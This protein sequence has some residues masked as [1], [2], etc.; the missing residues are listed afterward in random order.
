MKQNG[1]CKSL[2][3][4]ELN[5]RLRLSLLLPEFQY[6]LSDIDIPLSICTSLYSTCCSDLNRNQEPKY[7]GQSLGDPMIILI[8]AL[9]L[10]KISQDFVRRKI[11]RKISQEHRNSR[12]PH[13]LC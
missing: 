11:V 8:L 9:M 4:L 5:V 1:Y 13:L 12:A 3:E 7:L 6:N 2:K 10:N